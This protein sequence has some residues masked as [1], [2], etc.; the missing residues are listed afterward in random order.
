MENWRPLQVESSGGLRLVLDD[1]NDGTPFV[2]ALLADL[3]R[4]RVRPRPQADSKT[5]HLRIVYLGGPSQRA[6][7]IGTLR[8]MG[9]DLNLLTA[10]SL[11][12]WAPLDLSVTKLSPS[13][14]PW[15]PKAGHERAPGAPDDGHPETLTVVLGH[16]NLLSSMANQGL[17]EIMKLVI[18]LEAQSETV[19]LQCDARGSLGRRLGRWLVHRAISTVL[20]R[21]PQSQEVPTQYAH[22]EAS[23]IKDHHVQFGPG[24]APVHEIFLFKANET[25]LLV[26]P[27]RCEAA[28]LI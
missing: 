3:I 19:I 24:L 23:I 21:L 14:N 2:F 5:S 26:M 17:G 1:G 7:T 18:E 27:A 22:G 6:T 8:R 11:V 9:I 25:S 12:S 16:L 13:L 28:L 20:V 4:Q 15:T 10:L